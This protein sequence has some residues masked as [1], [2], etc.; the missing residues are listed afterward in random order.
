MSDPGSL[1]TH[2]ERLKA[3]ERAAL[4]PL[5]EHYFSRL[6]ELARRQLRGRAVGGADAEDVALSAFDSFCRGVEGGRFPRLEDRDDLWQ[7]LLLLLRQKALDL[8]Q[9]EARGKRGG[10]QVRHFSEL[11]DGEAGSAEGLFARCF[12]PEPTP[13]FAAE[14]AEECRRLLGL[15]GEDELRSIAVCKMEGYAN[16]EIAGRLG[17]SLATVERRLKLIRKIW[18]R[19]AV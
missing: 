19:E 14:V 15:L 10:G 7:V 11:A 8:I 9:H 18:S 17:C 13:D 16:E 1:S 5:W 12:G 2:L 3:G 6:V 4:R